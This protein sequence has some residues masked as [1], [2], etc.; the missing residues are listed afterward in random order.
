MTWVVLGLVVYIIAR[1]VLVYLEKRETVRRYEDRIDDL[2]NRKLAPDFQAYGYHTTYM[3]K[4]RKVK[5]GQ[6]QLTFPELE[7]LVEERQQE[8]EEVGLVPPFIAQTKPP[9]RAS[10]LRG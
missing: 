7:Q 8:T 4:L 6:A 5:K 3:A 10:S 9:P 2:L 1:E